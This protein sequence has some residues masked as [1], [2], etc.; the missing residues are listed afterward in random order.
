MTYQE[1]KEQSL[2]S[3]KKRK[4]QEELTAVYIN[5]TSGCREGK[6]RV[7]SKQQNGR[8]RSNRRKLQHGKLGLNISKIKLQSGWLNTGTGLPEGS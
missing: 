8:T 1:R 7:F 5:Q 4:L 2:F 6:A 3:H